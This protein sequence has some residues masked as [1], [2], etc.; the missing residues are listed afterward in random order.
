[1]LEIDL[2]LVKVSDY[3]LFVLLSHH[4]TVE[5][6]VLRVLLK[7]Y[8]KDPFLMVCFFENTK[9]IKTK[10]GQVDYILGTQTPKSGMSCQMGRR[11][12]VVIITTCT[13]PLAVQT[14]SI[15]KRL[16]LSWRCVDQHH[17]LQ[18]ILLGR[19]PPGSISIDIID[20]FV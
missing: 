8:R 7:S 18:D 5:H 12:N 2:Q 16:V 6:D 20:V 1:M 3:W 15:A 19:S 17:I 14:P 10:P 4:S 11:K 9:K 13:I